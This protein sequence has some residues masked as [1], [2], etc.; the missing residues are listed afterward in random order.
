M[1]K[2]EIGGSWD[3]GGCCCNCQHQIRLNCHPWN[4]KIGRGN[5]STKMGTVCMAMINTTPPT[6]E[7]LKSDYNAG[8]FFDGDHGYCELWSDAEKPIKD[9]LKEQ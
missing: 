1:R 3:D 7:H 5:I 2:C 9:S 4:Q 6:T 8:I